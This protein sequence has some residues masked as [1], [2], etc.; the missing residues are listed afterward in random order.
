ML[1]KKRITP[2]GVYINKYF[3]NIYCLNLDKRTSKW[4]AVKKQLDRYGIIV[5][6]FSAAGPN[7][8]VVKNNF[9]KLCKVH[10][11]MKERKKR[12][13]IDSI[14]AMGCLISHTRI[15]KDAKRNGYKKILILEDDIIL[16]KNFLEKFN[17][18]SR[19]PPWK[20]LYLGGSQHGWKSVNI[21]KRGFYKAVNTCGT[22]AYAIDHSIYNKLLKKFSNK[23]L[24]VDSYLISFQKSPDSSSYVFYPNIIIADVRAS[25]IRDPRDQEEHSKKMKWDLSSYEYFKR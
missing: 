7:D 18:I 14:G 25:D 11:K 13:L 2:G 15:I 23:K 4:L 20:L 22:F 17:N 24:P 10:P 9:K 21:N 3:D 8:F 5:E 16:A 1:I 12:A 19:L 6:R